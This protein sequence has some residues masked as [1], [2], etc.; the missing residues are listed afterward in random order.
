MMKHDLWLHGLSYS[1]IHV[2]LFQNDRLTLICQIQY[3]AE[4]NPFRSIDL[5]FLLVEVARFEPSIKHIQH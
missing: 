1:V 3:A 4:E 5:R 2:G